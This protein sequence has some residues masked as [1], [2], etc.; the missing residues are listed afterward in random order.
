MIADFE[1][2]DA[3]DHA[4]YVVVG[5]GA[6]GLLLAACLSRQ[7]RKVLVLE[8]GARGYNAASQSLNTSTISG[9]PH[10]GVTSGRARLLGGTS[11]L[12]GGQLIAF[13]KIDMEARPWLGLAGWPIGRDELSPYYSKVAQVLGLDSTSAD[14]ES[15]WQEIKLKSPNLDPHFTVILTRW[16]KEP[17]LARYF[18]EE[19]EGSSD[20]NVLLHAHCTGFQFNDDGKSISAVSIASPSGRKA[21]VKADNVIIASGT[22]EASRQMLLAAEKGA[23][24]AAN[25]WVG[26]CFQD[27]LDARSAK[28]HIKNKRAFHDKFDNI[29]VRGFKYQPKIK[30]KGSFQE[31]N[32]TTNIAASFV[33]DSDIAEHISKLK[34]A[35]RSIIRGAKPDNLADLFKSIKG[36]SSVWLPLVLRYLRD[37]RIMQ[38]SDR[39]LYL[40]THCEQIPISE[41]RVSLSATE[42]DA[43]DMPLVDLNWQV[44]GREIDGVRRFVKALGA[45]LEAEGIATLE[46][47]PRLEGGDADFLDACQDTN[48]QCGGLRMAVSPTD[49]VTDTNSKVHGCDNLYVAGAAVFPSSSFANPTFTAMALAVRLAEHLQAQA[50][51]Q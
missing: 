25:P 13:D 49:G 33:A 38:V 47:D 12:W 50:T 45:I 39:G 9:R 42:R 15:V 3:P 14:D 20:L 44:D 22:I 23:P 1:V 7:G 31:E 51:A 37:N 5:A 32:A 30:S 19:L 4:P 41:S 36:A 43:F 48:H 24:W 35:I 11:T 21:N 8:T 18:S 27:H 46:I 2:S 6:V 10:L 34:I 28:V 17:N 16:L 29:V 26:R 40:V